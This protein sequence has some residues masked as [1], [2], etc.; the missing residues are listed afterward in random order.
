MSMKWVGRLHHNVMDETHIKNQQ[1]FL[2]IRGINQQNFLLTTTYHLI[3]DLV[4]YI[5]ENG[6]YFHSI[7][8]AV[9]LVA[10]FQIQN[11][12]IQTGWLRF[13]DHNRL[14][15]SI[16]NF[17]FCHKVQ[18]CKGVSTIITLLFL[19]HHKQ[20]YFLC[21][22][23]IVEMNCMSEIVSCSC[24]SNNMKGKTIGKALWKHSRMVFCGQW[25]HV[26]QDIN[27]Y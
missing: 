17:R 4:T 24:M 7:H 25:C 10:R 19:I 12:P 21:N 15:T 11:Q 27:Q 5:Y 26:F 2:L 3:S 23:V 20:V 22:Y 14:P 16:R 13:V 18:S 9:M 1:N 6:L 8:A